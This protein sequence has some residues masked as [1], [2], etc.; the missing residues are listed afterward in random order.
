MTTLCHQ[1]SHTEPVLNVLITLTEQH[2][3]GTSAAGPDWRGWRSL[4]C[5][6]LAVAMSGCVQTT[7]DFTPPTTAATTAPI[8]LN[9]AAAGPHPAGSS[10]PATAP[11]ATS[12]PGAVTTSPAPPPEPAATV[13]TPVTKVAVMPKPVP[14][15]P[16]PPVASADGT[17]PFPETAPSAAAPVPA[18]TADGYP[19]INIP[20]AQPTGTLLPPDERKRIISELEALRA[21]QGGPAPAG[22][23]SAKALTSEAETHGAAAIKK[24]EACS[25]EGAADNPDCQPPAE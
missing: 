16:P 4:A 25:E 11:Q 23:G 24:I 22:A 21:K 9:D 3:G 18:T 5:V 13:P 10:A 19:N 2:D 15:P 17:E 7:A 6:A 8:V 12:S 20:P 1:Y 14:A